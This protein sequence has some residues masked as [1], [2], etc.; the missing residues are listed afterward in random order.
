MRSDSELG[1]ER[2]RDDKDYDYYGPFYD[3]LQW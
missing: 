3:Q 2:E 1:R